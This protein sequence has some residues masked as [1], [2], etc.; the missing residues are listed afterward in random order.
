MVCLLT[1]HDPA[2]LESIP[3]PQTLPRLTPDSVQD[4]IH[5]PFTRANGKPLLYV[6]F[7]VVPWTRP[8]QR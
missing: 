2:P 6:S 5:L 4:W 1:D 3:Y 7:G 8:R